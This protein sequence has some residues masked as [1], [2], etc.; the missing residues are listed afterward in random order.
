GVVPALSAD[1]LLAAVPGLADLDIEVR[2]EDFR[3]LPGASLG[4]ED[5]TAVVNLIADRFSDGADGV[6]V[7]QGTDTIEE[8]S[9]LFDLYH[10]GPQPIVVTGAMRNPTLVGADGP[11]NLLAAIQTAAS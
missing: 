10:P 5:L 11:A 8:T 6:V 1:Q 2:T 7:V 4:F 3:R 9:Y